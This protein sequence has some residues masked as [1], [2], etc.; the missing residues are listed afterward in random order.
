MLLLSVEGAQRAAAAASTHA[1]PIVLC[2]QP[3]TAA[4]VGPLPRSIPENTHAP[5]LCVQASTWLWPE[6]SS[7][8]AQPRT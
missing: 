6:A 4:H 8:P 7:T 2:S 1:G 3:T 5:L